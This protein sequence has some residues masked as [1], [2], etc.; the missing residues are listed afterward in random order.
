VFEDNRLGAMDENGHSTGYRHALL[1]VEMIGGCLVSCF[2]ETVE[3]I[4]LSDVHFA[5]KAYIEFG[6]FW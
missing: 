1:V 4:S 3:N 2:A 6:H 5:T